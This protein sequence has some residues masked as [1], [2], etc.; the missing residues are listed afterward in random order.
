MSSV[1]VMTLDRAVRAEA[2]SF[3]PW[4]V[5]ENNPRCRDGH[6][7]KFLFCNL[8]M[9]LGFMAGQKLMSEAYSTHT[10]MKENIQNGNDR[11]VLVDC[12]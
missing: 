3:R 7:G 5:N 11:F 9:K 12:C 1:P 6:I 8:R 4:L 2:C 10:C